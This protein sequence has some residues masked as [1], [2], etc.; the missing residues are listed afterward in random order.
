MIPF[1]GTF[2]IVAIGK[3]VTMRSP[4]FSEDVRPLS[5]FK[6]KASKILE[7]VQRSR[8]P[9]LLTKRGRGVA[10]LIDLDEYERLVDR[11]EFIEA[12]KVGAAA[13]QAGDLHGH[14]EAE[15]ILNGFSGDH[16]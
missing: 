11:A 3:G 13:A 12:V 10:V 5:D 16:G 6:T 14:D 1:Y 7:Q 9:V 8:R 2:K 4:K 15:E